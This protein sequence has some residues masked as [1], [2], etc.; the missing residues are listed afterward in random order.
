[1]NLQY[2]YENTVSDF[3]NEV[4][5][6]NYTIGSKIIKT[7]TAIIYNIHN[8]SENASIRFPS[9]IDEI[10]DADVH[11]RYNM[12]EVYDINFIS[13][14]EPLETLMYR[15]S[16]HGRNILIKIMQLLQYKDISDPIS[17][18]KKY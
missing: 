16:S 6:D 14:T 5:Q 9:N 13:K 4:L 15:T 1:M 3:V 10:I 2:I 11:Q 17:K 12:C 7:I 8:A 18:W